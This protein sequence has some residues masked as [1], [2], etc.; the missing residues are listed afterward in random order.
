MHACLR[1]L[2]LESACVF[3]W[4]RGAFEEL[5][6]STKNAM[7]FFVLFFFGSPL[8]GLRLTIVMLSLFCFLQTLSPTCLFVFQLASTLFLLQGTLAFRM[9]RPITFASS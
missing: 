9:Q 4:R 7:L 8:I 3:E 2:F 1:I 6:E 5:V